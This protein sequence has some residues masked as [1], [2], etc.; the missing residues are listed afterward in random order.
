MYQSPIEIIYK[1]M[2]TE[3][4]NNVYKAVQE[5]G[6]SVDKDELI[7]ALRYDRNQYDKGYSDAKINVAKEI[8]EKITKIINIYLNNKYYSMGEMLYDLAELEE[9]YVKDNL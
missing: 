8:F 5:Y 9:K 1:E 3:F 6:V 2:Q 4:E 7:K